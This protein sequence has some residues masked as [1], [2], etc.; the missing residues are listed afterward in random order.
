MIYECHQSIEVLK[1]DL[2]KTAV[3]RFC[4]LLEIRPFEEI[5]KVK[6]QI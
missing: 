3:S 6:R 2:A 1:T 5:Y 4:M